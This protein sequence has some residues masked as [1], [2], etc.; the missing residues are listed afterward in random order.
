MEEKRRTDLR[1]ARGGG[2]RSDSEALKPEP[3]EARDL[4]ARG[5]RSLEK[6]PPELLCW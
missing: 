6:N 1:D 4:H 5:L 2:Q 3:S